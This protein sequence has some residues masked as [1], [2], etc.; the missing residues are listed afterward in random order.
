MKLP[1]TT[2]LLFV[3]LGANAQ[4]PVTKTASS[5]TTALIILPVDS[6]SK[7][8]TYAE[9]VQAPQLTQ[10]ELYTRGKVWFV[11]T[12]KSA[13]AVVQTE[14]KDAGLLIGTAWSPFTVKSMGIPITYKLWYT[15]R[16]AFKDGRYKYEINN[17]MTEAEPS[18]SNPSPNQSP[19]ESYLLV[20]Y[21]PGNFFYKTTSQGRQQVASVAEGLATS[22]KAALAKPATGN[23]W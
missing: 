22:I 8:V 23:D 21:K 5:K 2:L 14:E 17:F 1:I 9:V 3:A 13:K 16:L 20:E 19:I 7:L 15:V 18:T 11:N 10:A 12:F 4:T 6:V